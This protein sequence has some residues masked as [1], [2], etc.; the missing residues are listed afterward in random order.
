MDTFDDLDNIITLKYDDGNDTPFE[1]LDVIEYEDEEY[2]VL[3]PTDVPEGESGEVVIL[4][5]EGS[6]G[7]EEAYVGVE[8]QEA[9]DAVFEIF[10]E[11]FKDEFNFE[12]SGES[13]I[14]TED[15]SCTDKGKNNEVKDVISD[16]ELISLINK[17]KEG[18]IDL[19]TL[20]P[21]VLE[22]M[23]EM[24]EKEVAMK[25]KTLALKREKI[26]KLTE[27]LGGT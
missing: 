7:D 17:T 6:E 12:D 10:K 14:E 25:E 13:T 21:S 5:V 18:K 15:F 8:D 16:D 9:L 4:K 26:R 19:F 2:V 27:D 22:K 24:L 3:L 1:F 20:S 11:K 23:C